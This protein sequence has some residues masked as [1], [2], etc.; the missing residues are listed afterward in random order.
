[1]KKT[2][3]NGSI[4]GSFRDPS[5]FLFTRDGKLFRQVNTLYKDD[6]DHLMQSGLYQ[7]LIDR[8]LMVPH[9]ESDVTP[10]RGK[11]AYK[12]IQPEKISFIS[13]PYEWCFTQLKQAA[14][15]TLEIQK[16]AFDF[17]MSLKDA[18]AYNIQFHKGKPVFIDTL[19]FEKYREGEPWVAYR[20]FCQH[21]LA[22]LALM[23]YTDIRLNQLLRVYIDGVPLDMA[24]TLL[25]F[26]T[27]LNFSLLSHLHLHSKS[28]SYFSDKSVGKRRYKMRRVSFLG[29]ISSLES[30]V[31]KLKWRAQGTEWAD[32]YNDT[33]YTRDGFRHKQETVGEFL[34]SVKPAGV[35]DLG[36]NVGVFS[37][38]ASDKQIPTISFDVDPSAV[39]KN[40]LEC[41]KRGEN[42]L[43]PLL[44]DL[45]NPSPGVGWSND[46]RMSLIERGPVDAVLALALVHHLAISNNLPF[47]MIA[48]FLSEIC[49]SLIIE[50]VPKTDS[51]VKRLLVVRE[52]IF[53]DYTEEAFEHEFEKRFT[54]KERVRIKDSERTLYLM[55]RAGA[56]S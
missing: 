36:G 51:Q 12:I 2:P 16:T 5:G 6:Y 14:L 53:T 39:E 15:T 1:M 18:S 17:G 11:G 45:A 42:H 52:D 4:P 34:D 26:R 41:V 28:Q 54:I 49:R 7:A 22:P 33:N 56:E 25:P 23:A 30:A 40:Y 21:F 13:Y 27:R 35:W 38:I 47:T 10:E 3:S 55:K 24:S 50:Y 32:Y 29:V 9:C 43:L 44:L 37:R 20:Q 46:E 48:R 19:S 8:G 31:R